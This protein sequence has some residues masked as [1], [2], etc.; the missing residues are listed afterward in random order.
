[1]SSLQQII[2]IGDEYPKFEQDN[3]KIETN[4][5]ERSILESLSEES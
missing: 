4:M 2:Q 5:L 1:M 3:G